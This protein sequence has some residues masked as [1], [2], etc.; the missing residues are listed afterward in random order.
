MLSTT[1]STIAICIQMRSSVRIVIFAF[2]AAFAVS[3][4][5]HGAS[6]AV[7]IAKMALGDGM[8]MADCEGC[9]P[10]GGKGDAG[11]ACDLVCTTPLAGTVCADKAL[12]PPVT[13]H[14]DDDVALGA[15]GR[16]GPPDP[17]PPR[18]SS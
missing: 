8:H 6:A 14:A 11:S 16:T 9:G 4:V 3:T 7:M 17:Y 10:A 18:L 13:E 2:L 15:V 1:G 12:Q 5:A